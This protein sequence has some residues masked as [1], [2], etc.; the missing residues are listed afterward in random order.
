MNE[1]QMMLMIIESGSQWFS[2]WF[3]SLKPWV[4]ELPFLHIFFEEMESSVR[5]I[6][7]VLISRSAF[8]SADEVLHNKQHVVHQQ[9]NTPISVQISESYDH[10]LPHIHVETG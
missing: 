2:Y 4:S 10:A 7:I 1:K 8:S 9:D 3:S 5:L 6:E